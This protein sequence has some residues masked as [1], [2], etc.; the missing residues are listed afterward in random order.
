MFYGRSADII[1]GARGIYW[2]RDSMD[3]E[4]VPTSQAFSLPV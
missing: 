3:E 2:F 1:E 4:F